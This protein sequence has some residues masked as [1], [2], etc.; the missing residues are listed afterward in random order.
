[1]PRFYCVLLLLLPIHQALSGFEARLNQY[2]N[3]G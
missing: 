2:E 3:C 1:M